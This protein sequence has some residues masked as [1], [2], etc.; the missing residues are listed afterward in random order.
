MPIWSRDAVNDPELSVIIPVGDDR[1]VNLNL[2]LCALANQTFKG[3]EV[4][5]CC[6]GV[7]GVAPRLIK[8][9]NHLDLVYSWEPRKGQVNLG[10]VNRNRGARVA[11]TKQYVFI[12]S[13]IV[14]N[15]NALEVYIEGFW[16]FPV[17]A[18]CGPYHWLPPMKVTTDD[19]VNRWDDLV[20]G[21]LPRTQKP[22]YGHNVGRDPR[23]VP[24][25]KVSP[26]ALYCDYRRAI[27]MLSGNFAVHRNVFRGAGGFWESLQY[28]IDGA[29]GLAVYGAGFSWSFDA[30][31]VGYHLYHERVKGIIDGESMKKIHERFHSDD[32][33]LGQMDTSVGWHWGSRNG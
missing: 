12:D 9:Y 32:T 18:I 2:V 4:I 13:D 21:K 6:D 24:W 28:G 10:A 26:D 29:F 3:F 7:K 1:E 8:K 23:L 31:A 27:M 20:N 16:N 15:P 30:R 11:R 22:P 25:E 17:R 14:L 19:L 5:V 33:W